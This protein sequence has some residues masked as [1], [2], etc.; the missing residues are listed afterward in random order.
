M[1]HN[2]LYLKISLLPDSRISEQIVVR[3]AKKRSQ[4]VLEAADHEIDNDNFE[5]EDRAEKM[6]S[7]PVS[8]VYLLIHNLT[9]GVKILRNV[10][11][12]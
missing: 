4:S 7:V 1:D 2:I 12:A 6:A 8:F 11:N 9:F 3:R 5:V 10:F